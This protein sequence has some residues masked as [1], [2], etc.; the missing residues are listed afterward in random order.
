MATISSLGS[1]SGLDLSGILNKIMQ[2]EAQPLNLLNTQEAS[3]QSKISALGSLKGALSSL[4]S[5]VE[6]F[7][8]GSATTATTKFSTLSASVADSSIASA[9]SSSSAVPGTYKLE[10]FNL[11]NAQRLQ[12]AANPAIAAGSLRI[13]IGKV[14]GGVGSGGAFTADSTK[15]LNLTIP[16]DKAT[17]EGVRDAINAANGSVSAAI[18]D[19]GSG[20][21][22][23]QVVGKDTGTANVIQISGDNASLNYDPSTN[24]ATG[25][26]QSQAAADASIKVNDVAITSSSN[27]ITSAIDGVS[28][29][30]LKPTEAGK[31][32][33]VSVT[34]SNSALNSILGD[35]VKNYNEVVKSAKS[36]STF[37]P[38]ATRGVAGQ[39]GPLLGDA[40]LR[41]VQSQ[42]RSALFATPNGSSGDL[43]SLSDLG[44][45]ME[46]DGTLSFD[47]SKLTKAIGK[48][49][50]AVANLAGAIGN[51]FKKTLE[52]LTGA[53]GIIADRTDGL[54]D[55]IKL[56]DKQR[57]VMNQ[58]L[59]AMQNRYIKQFTALDSLVA[60][61]QQTSSYLTQQLASLANL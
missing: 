16:S 24:S 18:V 5:S 40:T 36:M 25:L 4:Q 30:L 42:L 8:V 60:K 33:N 57:E 7:A 15:T 53:D 38:S 10:V 50:G 58:R 14:D 59:E 52:G 28:L 21:R 23:L 12:S 35:F 37:T 17:L 43:S 9:T 32:T 26:S 19:N 13:E 56:L 3:Y 45:K 31:T 27:T 20:G 54:Q 41:N 34:Q 51:N 47:S 11:A 44:V 6:K 29:T 46:K 1:G 39:S 2:V 48:D 49:F 55:R 61:N 22:F